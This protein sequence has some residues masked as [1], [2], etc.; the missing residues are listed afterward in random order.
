MNVYPLIIVLLFLPLSFWPK[1]RFYE[2][3]LEEELVTTPTSPP[4]P[5]LLNAYSASASWCLCGL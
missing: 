4:N 1:V 3:I 2:A 5:L